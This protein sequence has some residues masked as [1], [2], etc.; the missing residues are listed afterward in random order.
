MTKNTRLSAEERRLS[1]LAA[2]A[3]LFAK[4]GFDGATTKQIA[5]AANVSEAL[6]YKHFPSKEAIYEEL[7]NV[8]CHDKI[9]VSQRMSEL[10]PSTSTL[11]HAI[12]FLIRTIFLGESNSG[13]PAV[14]DHDH[15]HRLMAHSYLEDGEFAR[16]FMNENV[17]VWEPIL[18]QCIEAARAA[19]D[20][21][22]NG[23]DNKVRMWLSHH[24]GV[25]LGFLNLP[26]TPVIDYGVSEEALVD[27][28]VRFCLR[29]MGLT[30]RAIETHYNPSAQ[31]LFTQKL[32][33]PQETAGD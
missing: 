17:Q 21:V 9:L 23:I 5:H 8:C 26:R 19:G 24:I 18:S 7:K 16:I 12:Y 11:V 4:K 3:P 30:D 33:A 29:G 22:D 13:N 32:H 10:Q 25:A 15:I 6:L 1:I 31:A 14:A 2:A 20:L 28:A 27:Q